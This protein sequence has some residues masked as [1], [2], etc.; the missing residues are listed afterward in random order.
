MANWFSFARNPPELPSDA[1]VV[2]SGSNDATDLNPG[3]KLRLFAATWKNPHP[4][5]AIATIDVSSKVLDADLF[6]VA[7]TLE[8]DGPP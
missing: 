6:L 1:R 3:I 8:R 7:L 2:W 5:R 4:E